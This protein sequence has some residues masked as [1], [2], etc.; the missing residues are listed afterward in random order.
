MASS[1]TTAFL[2]APSLLINVFRHHRHCNQPLSI[3]THPRKSSLRVNL[4][5]KSTL[6]TD[7]TVVSSSTRKL[8]KH[9]NVAGPHITTQTV[10]DILLS[11]M[12]REYVA[13][14]RKLSATL[15]TA[16]DRVL[17]LMY[18]VGDFFESFFEDAHLLSKTCE[19]ALTSK[20]AG[21]ALG[22]RIPMAGLPHFAIDDKIKMLVA[23]NV[24]VAVVDQMQPASQKASG[25]LVKRAVTR[26]ITPATVTH[27]G[28]SDSAATSYVAAVF[29]KPSPPTRLAGVRGMATNPD[30]V[31]FHFGFAYADLSTG[32]FRTTD[33]VS[34][35]DLRRL[36][37]THIPA[38]LLISMTVD[39]TA[40]FSQIIEEASQA[41]IG[42]VTRQDVVPDTQARDIVTAFHKV[43]SV[44]SLG[45]REKPNSVQAAAMVLSFIDNTL[46]IEV[47]QGN[48]L[49]LNMLSTFSSS[50]FMMLD[51][52]CIRN[53]EV[54]ESVRDRAKE[55][56]LQWAVDRTVT[57]M[58]A[59]CLRSW[60]L[61]PSMD[62][63]VISARQR[64]VHAMLYNTADLRQDVQTTLKGL[65]DLERLGGR[66]G[67]ARITPREIQWLSASVLRLPNLFS[68]LENID[69]KDNM[70]AT[71]FQ[72][73]WVRTVDGELLQLAEEVQDALLEP[74]PSLLVSEVAIHGGSLAKENWNSSSVRIFRDGYDTKLDRLRQAVREPESWIADIEERERARSSID[75]LRIRH[76]KNVGYVLRV[77]RT[78]GERVM[79]TD[80]TF[81]SKL[82]YIRVQSTK[83]EIRFQFDELR[84]KEK[85]FNSSVSEMLL[86][87]LGLFSSLRERLVPFV[88]HLRSL[89]SQVAE[90]DVLT[91][92]AQ[93]AEERQYIKPDVLPA[94]ERVLECVD[95][96][97]AVVEQMLG[98]EKTF[99]PNSFK[100][101]SDKDISHPDMMLLCG[102]NAAGKSCALRSIGLISIL[103]QIG[104]FVPAQSARLSLCDRIFTR[105][106]AVDDMARGQST[107]QVEMAETACILSHASCSSLVL[108]DEIGRG[109]STVDGIAIAWSVAERLSQGDRNGTYQAPRAMFVTH[110]HELNH[111]SKL[112][113]NV[114]SFHVKMVSNMKFD[115]EYGEKG[116]SEEEWVS[117]HSIEAGPSYVSLGLALAERAGF[118][119]DVMMRARE[120]AKIL[121]MP[122]K[123]LGS[124]LQSALSKDS[125]GEGTKSIHRLMIDDIQ[126]GHC[127][128]D[129]RHY[130][131]G[132]ADGYRKAVE[133]MSANC[134]QLLLRVNETDVHDS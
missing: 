56:S 55:R 51:A 13:T 68:S 114:Q 106:G 120:I 92:F 54:L 107:F 32:E 96:R 34:L 31:P 109:T 126:E 134:R 66:V 124:E 17:V 15:C 79:D 52:S 30:D 119:M 7:D 118:P 58:G 45:C 86:Y 28:I 47:E 81:F 90:I 23:A 10:D 121:A 87:E 3:S 12:M 2:G 44:E 24:T 85:D 62:L 102:P 116:S 105:V 113:E 80:P 35:D 46:A 117:T 20:E 48:G 1:T 19:I 64:V 74:A 60:L 103:A 70:C 59:R 33:G 14:K 99:V 111:L 69:E 82:G 22:M 39:D 53:L 123:I 122:S 9:T 131:D 128:G 71:A 97:H 38:E 104:S 76:I 11:P 93:V 6:R 101:G 100:L 72:S 36:L 18:R 127:E 112:Y 115:D 8:E 89:G 129:A 57:R 78:S 27:D 50:D 95:A 37:V 42:V 67:T 84:A 108:L 4:L 21:K 61:R 132:F 110:F 41:G 25:Q 16:S 73:Q 130:K 91:G 75:S 125:P 5:P 94:T 65:A 88:Q 49:Q 43:D 63:D 98:A 83:S 77:P 133:E 40:L 29:A 26:L